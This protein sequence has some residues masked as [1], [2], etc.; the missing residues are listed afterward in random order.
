MSFSA[1]TFLVAPHAILRIFTSEASV[2]EVGSGLLAIA[3]AFQLFDGVQVVATGA[4]RGSGDT[5][6]SMLTS[7]V[8]YWLVSLPL[9]AFLC[10]S[11]DLGVYGLWGGLTFGLVFA[12]IALVWAWSRRTRRLPEF[13][14]VA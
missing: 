4:L 3:A 9:G 12:A 2:I 10:F 1:I 14:A 11:L 13:A 8:G 6:T 7:L 5:R